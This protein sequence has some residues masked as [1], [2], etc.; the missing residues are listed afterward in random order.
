MSFCHLLEWL[1]VKFKTLSKEFPVLHDLI[2]SPFSPM[3]SIYSSHTGLFFFPV[4]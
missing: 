2:S 3:C 4:L 1:P